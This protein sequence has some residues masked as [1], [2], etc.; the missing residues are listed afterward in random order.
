MST[1]IFMRM[2]SRWQLL[3]KIVVV[4]V[5]YYVFEKFGDFMHFINVFQQ[6]EYTPFFPPA[7]IAFGLIIIWGKAIWPGIGIAS[8]LFSVSS[9]WESETQPELLPV[10][11]TATMV[12]AARVLEPLAGK[13]LMDK[14]IP[15]GDPFKGLRNSLA[16]IFIIMVISIVGSA[17]SSTVFQLLRKEDTMVYLSRLVAW[18]GDNL[19]GIMVFTPFI[20]ALYDIKNNL[21]ITKY[22]II[23]IAILIILLLV[24]ILFFSSGYTFYRII[25][26]SLPFITI[27]IFLWLAFRYH[28]IVSSV[29]L[30]AISITAVYFTTGGYGPFIHVDLKDS[31]LLLQNFL[32]VS[33][34]TIMILYA[35]SNERKQAQLLLEQQANQLKQSI[36]DLS[37]ARIKA[38]ES[39]RLKSAFLA[40][41]SHEV[42]TPMNVIMG[43]SELLETPSLPENKKK[44]F[45]EMIRE[46]GNHLLA[47][48]NDVI[49]MSK[50]EAGIIENTNVNTNIQDLFEK[51]VTT[52]KIETEWTKKNISFVII[53]E[54]KGTGNN[55]ITDPTHLEQ[56][57][58]NLIS[59]ALKFTSGGTIIIGCILNKNILKFSVR[60]TGIG[61]AKE[62][63]DIIFRPFRQADETVHRKYGGSGLGLSICKGFVEQWGGKIWVESEVNIGTTFYFTMPYLPGE[64]RVASKTES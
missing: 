52:F 24:F 3:L 31:V 2:S 57:L 37:E 50:I 35:A 13:Y 60:D 42:R 1:S 38:E 39:D 32:F 33:S 4:T 21:T 20:L 9:Y 30:I 61:I 10:V 14:W 45:T 7:G 55:V 12:A 47:V 46:R 29:G 36:H 54:L 56:V 8:L 40:N 63:S 18:Y 26:Y 23:E 34:A 64:P 62:K 48:L 41:M 25:I 49:Q 27:P 11:I 17:I 6:Q 43:V 19:V 15:S 51:L 28:L 16:F 53:N 22:L 44:E 58:T 59:N 5:L